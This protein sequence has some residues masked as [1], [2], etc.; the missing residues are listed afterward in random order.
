MDGPETFQVV[1]TNASAGT[2]ISSP[3]AAVVTIIG[4]V[5]GFELATNAYTTG[6]NGGSVVVTVNR[7]NVNTGVVSVN[8]ATSATAARWRGLIT[9]PPMAC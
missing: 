8:F 4:N 3:G 7:L 1:L 6:E 2:Q 9:W 5:T